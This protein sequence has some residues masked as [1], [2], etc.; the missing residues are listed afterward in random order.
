MLRVKGAYKSFG[1]I[2]AVCDVSFDLGDDRITGLVGPNGSGKTTL[3]HIISGFY[4]LDKGRIY[5][6]EVP[7]QNRPAHLISR[8]GLIRTFQHSRMLSFLSVRDNLIAAAPRQSGERIVNLFFK[9]GRVRS[10][11][12]ACR[13]EAD[14]ILD[15]LKISH[16]ADQPAERLSYGQQ[17]LLEIGRVLMAS[18]KL[19]LLD[20]PTAGVNPTLIRQIVD[21]ILELKKSGVRFFLVEHNMPLVSELCERLLVMDSGRL[22]FSGSPEEAVRDTQVIEAYLGRE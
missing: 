1:G 4:P 13:R 21:V 10:Q 7:I 14:R 17:K 2:T 9:P 5:F 18:P 19:I 11:E 6:R 12:T 16:L 22:I 20:E 3:F 8:Q 15:L